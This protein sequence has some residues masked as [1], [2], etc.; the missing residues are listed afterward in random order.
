M[1][2]ADTERMAGVLETMVRESHE[3]PML[4]IQH[5]LTGVTLPHRT[6]DVALVRR[7]E[8]ERSRWGVRGRRE[9]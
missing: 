6:S 4:C 5:Q 8:R 1:N 2:M 3:N 7:G 9:G